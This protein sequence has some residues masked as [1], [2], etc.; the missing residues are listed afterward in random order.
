MQAL[1]NNDLIQQS[2]RA[3]TNQGTANVAVQQAIICGPGFSRHRRRDAE[4]ERAARWATC[5]PRGSVPRL[6]R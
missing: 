4:H 2:D 1:M 6:H 3:D 5:H